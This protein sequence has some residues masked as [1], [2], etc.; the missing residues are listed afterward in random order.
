[1]DYQGGFEIFK[2]STEYMFKTP[3]LSDI[4]RVLLIFFAVIGVLIVLPY[5]ISKRIQLESKY[6]S[7]L[8]TAQSLGLTKEESNLLWSCAKKMPYDPN[9]FLSSKPVFERCVS[10]LVRIDP[11]KIESIN[12]V[13]KK[14]HFDYVPWFLPLTT[15][16]E[17]DLYQ[18]GFL[19]YGNHVYDAAVWDKNEMYLHIAI[20]DAT[21]STNIKA[22]DRIKF[23]FLRE[24]EGRY[25]FDTDVKEVYSDANRTVVVVKHLDKLNKIQLREHIRWRINIPAKIYTPIEEDLGLLDVS[26]SIEQ[27]EPLLGSIEDISVGGVRFCAKY[28]PEEIKEEKKIIVE[29]DLEGRHLEFVGVVRSRRSLTDRICLGIKFENI[30]DDE[31]NYINKFILEKQ[32]EMLKKYKAKET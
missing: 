13:R 25:Y 7:F 30:T 18:T 9:K 5:F 12:S 3:D 26:L 14:L 24:D 11:S 1:M 23:S 2:K 4:L 32:R 17:L 6:K 8:E 29:F 10:F 22:G 27:L 15:T 19:T 20:L 21:V 28:I 31:A 16:R